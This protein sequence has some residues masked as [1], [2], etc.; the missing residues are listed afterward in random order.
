MSTGAGVVHGGS[1]TLV[2]NF[3]NNGPAGLNFGKRLVKSSGHCKW[4]KHD[5][6]SRKSNHQFAF[7]FLDTVLRYPDY[8]SMTPTNLVSMMRPLMTAFGGP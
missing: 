7:S 2:F 6:I 1:P 4:S 5:Q 3:L 8:R